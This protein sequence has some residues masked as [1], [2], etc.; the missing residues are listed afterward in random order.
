[1]AGT[2]AVGAT[3]EV[4][5]VIRPEDARSYARATGQD[6]DRLVDGAPAPALFPTIA[7]GPA[8]HELYVNMFRDPEP[9]VV[10]L[11]FDSH[12]HHPVRVGH[13]YHATAA[14]TGVQPTARGTFFY[15]HNALWD[16]GGTRCLDAYSTLLLPGQRDHAEEGVGPPD[17]RLPELRRRHSALRQVVV[18]TREHTEHYA[19][20]SNDWQK[21]HFEDEAARALGLAGPIMHGGTTMGMCAAFVAKALCDGDVTRLVRFAMRLTVPVYPG[22]QLVIEISEPVAVA[23]GAAHAV[24]MLCDGRAV[25]RGGRA[26]VRP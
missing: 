24:R 21:L 5:I 6:V 20:S 15:Q 14:V 12:F 19:Q 11:G 2:L 1:L 9:V 25:A 13:R 7:T 4:D 16:A 3:G 22:S 23:G 18:P 26:D 17:V 8:T 10:H